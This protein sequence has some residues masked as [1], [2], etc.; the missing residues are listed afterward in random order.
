MQP[1]QGQGFPSAQPQ[2]MAMQPPQQMAMQP[3]Q[4]MAMQPLQGQGFAQPQQMAM[5]PPQPLMALQPQQQMAMQPPQQTALF[6]PN[7]QVQQQFQ[8]QQQQQV[9]QPP[10]RGGKGRQQQQ[11]QQQPGPASSLGGRRRTGE[12]I[13][14]S[15]WGGMAVEILNNL[16]HVLELLPFHVSQSLFQSTLIHVHL[17]DSNNAKEYLIRDLVA[18][19][20]ARRLSN[21][22]TQFEKQQHI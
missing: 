19:A 7:F 16:E 13:H 9:F 8:Q 17:Y 15:H 2:Q 5:Q 10:Q 18:Y 21:G 11:Q 6:N 1:L 20:G 3:P 14:A 22:K 4:Q 12:W